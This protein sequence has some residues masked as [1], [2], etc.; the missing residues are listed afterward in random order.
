M[1][2]R[3]A[4][5]QPY[6]VYCPNQVEKTLVED[7]R[8]KVRLVKTM[9]GVLRSIATWQQRAALRSDLSFKEKKEEEEEPVVYLSRNGAAVL[10][11][12]GHAT[13]ADVS[14]V[15]AATDAW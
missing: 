6:Y 9:S 1:G 2:L 12:D 3:A 14:R 7:A 13:K 8:N 4:L 10:A 11:S 15:A 5:S